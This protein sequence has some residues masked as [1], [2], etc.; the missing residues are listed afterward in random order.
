M[1]GRVWSKRADGRSFVGNRPSRRLR[2]FGVHRREGRAS[3]RPNPGDGRSHRA[4]D[5]LG[6]PDAMAPREIAGH[7]HQ[8]AAPGFVRLVG[9]SDAGH[10]LTPCVLGPR[11]AANAWCH[12]SRV[13]AS[14]CI[15]GWMKWWSANGLVIG[16]SDHVGSLLAVCQDTAPAAGR[17]GGAFL[18]LKAGTRS[19]VE[20]ALC[21]TL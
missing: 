10:A 3:M 4:Q 1:Y 14:L 6:S 12:E 2:R 9:D 20:V 5:R 8:D 15:V 19:T 21:F 17:A 18:S 16:L 7:R 11:D 13:R